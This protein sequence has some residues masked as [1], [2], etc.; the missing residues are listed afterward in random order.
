MVLIGNFD[1]T[2]DDVTEGCAIAQETG[3]LVL[4]ALA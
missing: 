4:A 2:Y 3:C 1:L